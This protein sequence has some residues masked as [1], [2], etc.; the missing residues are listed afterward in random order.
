MNILV[1][2]PNN[3]GWCNPIFSL[4]GIISILFIFTLVCMLLG[5]LTLRIFKIEWRF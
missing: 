4:I 3:I 2:E 5:Y 1:C